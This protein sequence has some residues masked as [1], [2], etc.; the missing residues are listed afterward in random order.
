[1]KRLVLSTLIA[2]LPIAACATPAPPADEATVATATAA[3]TVIFL[4]RHAEAMYPPPE[5]APRNP[6]LSAMGQDRADAL[7]RLLADA[8]IT[9]IHSTDYERTQETAAPLAALLGLP[10]A[11][12]DPGDLPGFA[13]QLSSTP[14]RHVVLGHS[15]TTPELVAA[16]GGEPG[17]P[18]DESIEF[19]RLYVVVIGADGAVTTS[20]LRYGAPTPADW[21]ERAAAR[22]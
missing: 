19:D 15:N 6:P 7:A 9:L 20:L 5:D 14:G 16:L 3:S 12:Y 4:A 18:I 10:V 13:A 8:G 2:L 11:A 22:R 21:Q 1:M 17:A